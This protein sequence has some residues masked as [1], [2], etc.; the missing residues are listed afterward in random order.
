MPSPSKL[1]ELRRI[2]DNT[3]KDYGWFVQAVLPSSEDPSFAYSIGLLEN[4]Q[5]PELIMVGFDPKLCQTL[6]NTVGEMVRSGSKFSDGDRVQEVI[7]GFPVAIREIPGPVA[8]KWARGA[9]NRSSGR[10]LELLQIFLPDVDGKFPW[11]DG[12][13]QQYV[14]VQGKLLGLTS[15]LH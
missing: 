7:Q 2:I 9:A 3:V 8:R 15:T 1:D 6:I 4:F 14:N 10:N 13:N 12:C 11:E 5:H